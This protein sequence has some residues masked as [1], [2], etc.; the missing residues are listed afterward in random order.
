M[1][2]E[3]ISES[4]IKYHCR[5][6]LMYIFLDTLFFWYNI[7]VFC[8]LIQICLTKT[9]KTAIPNLLSRS[10]LQSLVFHLNNK[11]NINSSIAK[12]VR[13]TVMLHFA[14]KLMIL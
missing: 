10:H 5:T 8:I 1:H 2:A 13:S 4:I 14:N 11:S 6:S 12:G 7:L 9:T 3:I